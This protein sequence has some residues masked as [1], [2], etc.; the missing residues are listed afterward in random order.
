MDALCR[1]NVYTAS[2]RG[3]KLYERKPIGIEEFVQGVGF[4]SF[5]SVGQLQGLHLPNSHGNLIA[6]QKNPKR[7]S[8]EKKVLAK[9]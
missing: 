3:L 6:K 1:M 5:H 8:Q 9:L 7:A 4:V 2:V